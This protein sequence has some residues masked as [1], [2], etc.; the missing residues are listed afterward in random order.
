MEILVIKVKKSVTPL[1]TT[2]QN[3]LC[4]MLFFV[5]SAVLLAAAVK[6]SKILRYVYHSMYS[7][8]DAYDTNSTDVYLVTYCCRVASLAPPLVIL[9]GK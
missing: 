2:S 9:R 6:I 3:S 5:F 4:R 8:T 1:L 7:S